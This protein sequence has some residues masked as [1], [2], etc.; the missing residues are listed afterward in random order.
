LSRWRAR[1][2]KQDATTCTV[3]KSFFDTNILATPISATVL[4]HTEF[5]FICFVNNSN[6]HS[7]VQNS[8]LDNL[9]YF[10]NG[11]AHFGD[12]FQILLP[13]WPVTVRR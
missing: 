11:Y 5:Y 7:P 12:I 6:I 8:P 4:H 10:N 13:S 2:A 1:P 3:F 9:R